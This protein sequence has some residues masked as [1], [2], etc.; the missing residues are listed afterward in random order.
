MVTKA[1]VKTQVERRRLHLDYS[2]WMAEGE[3]LAGMFAVIDP[4]TD[5]APLI[6]DQGMPNL[7]L[8]QFIFYI[9]GGRANTSYLVQLIAE[10]DLGQIKRDDISMRVRP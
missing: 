5:D 9:S 8:D 7:E 10:T 1:F 3:Q 4:V 6:L 2:C